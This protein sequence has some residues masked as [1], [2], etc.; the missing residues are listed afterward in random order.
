MT[1]CVA[2]LSGNLRVW[3]IACYLISAVISLEGI[4]PADTFQNYLDSAFRN[5]QAKL[6]TNIV[7]N[8]TICNRVGIVFNENLE[9]ERAK[10]VKVVFALVYVNFQ[11]RQ[12]GERVR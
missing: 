7:A 6:F 3:Q 5:L 11:N 10:V 2:L 8:N 9:N 1:F 4:F 12:T